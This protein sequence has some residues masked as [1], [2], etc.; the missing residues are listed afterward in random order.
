MTDDI[1][2]FFALSRA[3]LVPAEK[4]F[5]EQ[6]KHAKNKL[7]ECTGI[8]VLGAGVAVASVH[9]TPLVVVGGLLGLCGFGGQMYYT[10]KEAFYKAI[11]DAQKKQPPAPKAASGPIAPGPA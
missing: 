4:N 8:G 6:A 7:W 9:I 3:E 10:F 11:D 5:G 1:T 2:R